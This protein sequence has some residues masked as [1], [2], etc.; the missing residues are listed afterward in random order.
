MSAASSNIHHFLHVVSGIAS[1]S[2]TSNKT[3]VVHYAPNVLRSEEMN[4]DLLANVL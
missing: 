1:H 3:H 4:D 2:T